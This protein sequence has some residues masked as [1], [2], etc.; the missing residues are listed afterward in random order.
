M[1]RR[2][3]RHYVRNTALATLGLYAIL[4]LVVLSLVAGAE[5]ARNAT[6]DNDTATAT[7]T[8]LSNQIG[9]ALPGLLSGLNSRRAG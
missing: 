5:S 6:P 9:Q 2:S 1:K 3:P 7:A 8:T 4:M